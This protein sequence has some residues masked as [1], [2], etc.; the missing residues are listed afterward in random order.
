MSG[1]HMPRQHGGEPSSGTVMRMTQQTRTQSEYAAVNEAVRTMRSASRRNHTCDAAL[2]TFP[3]SRPVP[4]SWIAAICKPESQDQTMGKPFRARVA[5][6]CSVVLGLF[7]VLVGVQLARTPELD[8]CADWAILRAARCAQL[9]PWSY[10]AGGLSVGVGLLVKDL[11][12]SQW[13]TTVLNA[14]A[15]IGL[16]WVVLV[17]GHVEATVGDTV[18]RLL[19]G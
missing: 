3:L 11:A 16:V 15:A 17:F 5:F 13:L 9:P 2:N 4:D 6:R 7:Y 18:V 8:Q 10:L 1:V 19:V 12:A 14:V